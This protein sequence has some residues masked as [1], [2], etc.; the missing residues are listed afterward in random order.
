MASQ[1]QWWDAVLR[2]D[3]NFDGRFVYAVRS[4][5]IYCRPTCPSRKPS[6]NQVIFFPV[7]GEAEQ[8]GFRPCRRCKPKEPLGTSSRLVQQACRYIR[9]NHTEPLKLADLSSHLKVSPG[10][11][12]RI[13][14]RCLGV[15]PAQY[16][17]T[18]R[19]NTVKSHLHG[20]K[21]VTTAIYESGFGSSS[22]LYEKAQFRLGMT[23]ATY[24]KGGDGMRIS[25]AT[26]ACPLGHLLVAATARG[27]CAVTL[28]D[29]VPELRAA[30][31]REYPKAEIVDDRHALKNVLK[32]ILGYLNGD[33]TR[34]D[35]PLDVRA[36]AF[37]S[38]VWEKLRQIPYGTTRSYADIARTLGRPRAVRAVA[39]A[40]A[41]NPVA[42]VI[43][44]HR[45]VAQTGALSGYRWGIERKQALLTREQKRK[46]K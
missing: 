29:S 8:A 44:C 19:M 2:R 42:L 13:F 37:Q 41:T 30:L 26:A 14:K 25:Y 5:G 21:D 15:S 35:F 38:L 18:C 3:E 12:H 22:R 27:L 9:E 32:E 39:R 28:G 7:V 4:T 16:A 11:L 33:E 31:T 23:P 24:R 43:P 45:V 6:R 1:R 40:C 20:G 36:T 46:R 34:L 17:E 10:H